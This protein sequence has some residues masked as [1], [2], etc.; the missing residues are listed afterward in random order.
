M[1]QITIGI[2][3]FL[4]FFSCKEKHGIDMVFVGGGSFTMGMD[5]PI[6]TPMGDTLNGFTSPTREVKV[7]DFYISRY[8]IT[9]KEFKEFCR[10]TN[11]KMPDP[12]FIEPYRGDTII[13]VW[14][15]EYPMLATW[16]EANDFAQ[17]AGGRLPT[18][19]EWEYAARGGSKSEGYAYS[20]SDVAT[21]VGWV[22]ENADSTLHP[23]GLLKPNE[24]GLYDMTGNV[25]EWVFD[26]YNPE[27]DS[28][29][30]SEN[31]TGP[32]DG[33]LKISKGVGWYYNSVDKRTGQ[34]LEYGIH[35]PAVRY[36][37]RLDERSFGFG[38]RIV[39]DK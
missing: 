23:V 25:N 37:S 14:K 22:G 24:L 33:E 19:A 8:E 1:K 32:P 9:V 17:W 7:K 38:F 11:R 21:D 2:L 6:M 16:Y 10:E 13:Y 34:P 29:S 39:K 3:S 26:W 15:D 18:E 36:Q 35:V 27:R 28:L 20:G 5:R 4:A 12:P 31:P 30:G